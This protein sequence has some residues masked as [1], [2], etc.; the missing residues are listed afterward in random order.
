MYIVITAATVLLMS[1]ALVVAIWKHTSIE[2]L[3]DAEGNPL[4]WEKEALPLG[5]L[6]HPTL[7]EWTH[8]AIRAVAFWNNGADIDLFNF[9]GERGLVVLDTS[10][11][12][13]VEITP[14]DSDDKSST[15]LRYGSGGRVQAT[16]IY[17][18]PDTPPDL[19]SRVIAHELGHA[20]GLAHHYSSASAM[21]QTALAGDFSIMLEETRVLRKWY[22]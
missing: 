10:A 15:I 20:L 11:P 8:P 17:L 22:E 9:L 5:L 14:R 1:V 19:R 21:Y 18:D 2:I 13:L 7:S 4:R 12:G 3:E 6:L 16:P